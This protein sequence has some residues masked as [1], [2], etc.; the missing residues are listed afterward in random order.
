[1]WGEKEEKIENDTKQNQ[2]K[3]RCKEA[4][5]C[6]VDRWVWWGVRDGRRPQRRRIRAD[7][8]DVEVQTSCGERSTCSHV[9]FA[10]GL[11]RR[12]ISLCSCHSHFLRC[13]GGRLCG[14]LVLCFRKTTESSLH[15]TFYFY[16]DKTIFCPLGMDCIM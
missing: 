3:G 12:L 5:D 2:K 7:L 11:M 16:N 15:N 10:A 9:C 1:M 6:L 13:S 8:V 14:K 4:A